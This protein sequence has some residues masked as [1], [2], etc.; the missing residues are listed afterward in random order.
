M[1]NPQLVAQWKDRP[2]YPTDEPDTEAEIRLAVGESTNLFF[3]SRLNLRHW[4]IGSTNGF[5]SVTAKLSLD[6][7]PTVD[8]AA[9][10]L[11]TTNVANEVTL[12]LTGKARGT[13][14]IFFA[15]QYKLQEPEHTAKFRIIIGD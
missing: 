11:R 13:E 4:L 6:A 9:Y 3:R 7:V 14:D 8:Y 10:Q 5:S 15:R 12:T 2:S 1:D